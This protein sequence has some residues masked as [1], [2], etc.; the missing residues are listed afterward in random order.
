MATQDDKAYYTWLKLAKL[1]LIDIFNT[2]LRDSAISHILI[3][4][5]PDPYWMLPIADEKLAIIFLVSTFGSSISR[6]VG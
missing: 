2:A 6:K 5:Q 1:T 4:D 3:S